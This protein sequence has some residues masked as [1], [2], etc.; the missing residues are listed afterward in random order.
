VGTGNWNVASRFAL[1]LQVTD[2]ISAGFTFMDGDGTIIPDYR[3]LRLGY[4]FAGKLQFNLALGTAT[5]GGTVSGLGFD[6]IPFQRKYQ[7][8]FLTQF[9]VQMDYIFLPTAANGLTTG[10][11]FLGLAFSIGF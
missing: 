8:V 9:K 11:L 1:G 4:S 5:P 10:V 6:V 2:T 7:D 3:F